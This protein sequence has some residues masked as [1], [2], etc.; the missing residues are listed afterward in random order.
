[1]LQLSIPQSLDMNRTSFELYHSI[2]QCKSPVRKHFN[3]VGSIIVY[4]PRRDP[5]SH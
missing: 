1:M 3:L 5:S 4:R 2:K